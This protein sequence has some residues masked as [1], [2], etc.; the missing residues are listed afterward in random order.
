MLQVQVMET[1]K[2]VLRA[3]H[4]STLIGMNNLASIYWNQG[5]WKEAEELQVQVMETSKT[6]LGDEH[7]DT[8]ISMH[9]LA[10]TWK[11]LG[12]LQDVLALMENCSELYNKRLG[13][14]HPHTRSSCRA[15]SDWKGVQ[16]PLPN[17][18]MKLPQQCL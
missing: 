13:P 17:E 7:P 14:N 3:E 11:S 5:Q 8:L 15:L 2:T 4:P 18:I 12:K 10:C 1:K 16:N 6:V 9:N